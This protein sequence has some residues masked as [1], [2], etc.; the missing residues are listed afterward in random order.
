MRILIIAYDFPPCHSSGV[1]R[2]LKFAENLTEL[3]C[4]VR[5]LTA[6][7]N[8]YERV[9]NSQIVSEKLNGKIYRAKCLNL[10]KTLSYKGKYFS[11]VEMFEKIWPWYFTGKRLGCRIIEE[12][13]PDFIIS[14]YPAF[15]AHCI[16]Y[17]L[18]NE[19]NIPW[20]MDYRDPLRQHYDCNYKNLNYLYFILEKKFIGKCSGALFTSDEARF[21]YRK[22]YS[23]HKQKF[24]TIRNGYDQIM[25]DNSSNERILI[26]HS[27]VLY[28]DDRNID[29]LICAIADFL[30]C[31]PD[32]I[33]KTIVRF[34]GAEATLHQT[35]LI[36]KLG[37]SNIIEF[38]PSICYS[39]SIIEMSEANIL[40]VVQNGVL[41]NQIPG[42]IYDYI[43]SRKLIIC[44]TTKNSAIHE[45]KLNNIKFCYDKF[46]ILE[47]MIDCMKII[48]KP[49]GFN[50]IE[51]FSR[52][53][54][55]KR[56]YKYMNKFFKSS[57]F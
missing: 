11:F 15:T 40:L 21:M 29:E 5:V 43:A 16:A 9:D 49:L 3:G 33:L 27:G 51:K 24:I 35:K 2:T 10:K 7:E 18:V 30:N 55:S 28:P 13:K 4:D 12:F 50:D 34:R 31:F 19:F 56:L 47:C 39:E 48:R 57:A 22:L 1:Q 54:S 14:T 37:L 53:N 44:Y 8:S 45:I 41:T 6:D 26:L 25:P 36:E 46:S 42:K 20:I 52:F 38:K 23:T 17:Y 32:Y